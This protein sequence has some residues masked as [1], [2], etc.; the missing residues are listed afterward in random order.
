MTNSAAADPWDDSGGWR[1]RPPASEPEG[2]SGGRG[3]SLQI[4]WAEEIEPHLNSLW[5]IKKTLPQ[6]GIALIYGHPG[7]GKSFLAVDIALHIALGR[8]WNGLRTRRGAVVYV[9]AEGQKGLRNRIVAFKRHHGLTGPIPLALI[10]APIDLYESAADRHGLCA[11]VRE[12]SARYGEPPALIVIDTISKTLGAGKENTDDL[13]VYVSNCGHLAAEFGCCVMPVHHRPKDSESTEP[14]GHGSLK[15][16]VDTVILVEA[17][18]PKRA[19]ITKQK[20]DEERELLLFNLQP[21]ELGID[22]DGDSISS[23]VVVPTLDAFVETSANARK[24]ASLNPNQRIVFN[25]LGKAI[26]AEGILPPD[27][28]PADVIG[29]WVGKGVDLRTFSDRAL[30]ELRTATDTKADSA[31]RTFDRARAKLQSIG[32]IGV[33]E[34]F[35]WLIP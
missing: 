25:A 18:K 11:A 23:C 2:A 15:G 13:A 26:A 9:A 34:E 7:S 3:S 4:E 35:A 12:A 5:L 20:D 22:D 29:L 19:R 27:T 28:I 30:A 1:D 21:V 24:I 8:G 14:R 31:R 16:G 10:P 6:Q 17:G 33:W 32:L